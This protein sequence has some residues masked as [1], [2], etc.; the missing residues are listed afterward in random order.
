MERLQSLL[1]RVDALLRKPNVATTL[2]PDSILLT[3]PEEGDV[4]RVGDTVEV[5]W[6]VIGVT[7]HPL[8]VTLVHGRGRKI[9]DVAVLAARIPARDLS[10]RV[11]VPEVPAGQEYAV[12][13]V[14]SDP[15]EI[16]SRRFSISN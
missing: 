12:A 13:L 7:G 16:R 14:S 6:R 4:W 9:E 3:A 8:D 10:V 11:I 2:S 15:T 5:S 1:R